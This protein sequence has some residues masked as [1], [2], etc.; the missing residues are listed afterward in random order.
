MMEEMRLRKLKGMIVALVVVVLAMLV[1]ERSASP[2]PELD[3]DGGEEFVHVY[4]VGSSHA[5]KANTLSGMSCNVCP[6][7][8]LSLLC[9]C[10]CVYV[11]KA[12]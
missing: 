7:S 1:V 2:A 12:L 10:V 6:F 9:V 11:L 5:G 8:S 3:D 4:Q